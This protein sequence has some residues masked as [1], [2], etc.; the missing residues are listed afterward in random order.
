MAPQPT[1][2]PCNDD[3]LLWFRQTAQR[4]P[5]LTTLK[6]HGSEIIVSFEKTNCRVTIPEP[7]TRNLVLTL[8]MRHRKLQDCRCPVDKASRR[9]PS[10]TDVFTIEWIIKGQCPTLLQV[11]QHSWHSGEPRST[12]GVV[13]AVRCEP[14]WHYRRRIIVRT[15]HIQEILA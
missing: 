7:Q 11:I 3:V 1:Q 13:A 8:H 5:R 10:T 14:L 12:L 4:C 2:Q 9:H 15:V 6:E